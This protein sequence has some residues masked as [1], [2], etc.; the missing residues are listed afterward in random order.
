MSWLLLAALCALQPGWSTRE[1][2]SGRVYRIYAPAKAAAGLP[3]VLE[4]HGRGSNS[5]QQRVLSR[6]DDAADAGPF[7][8]VQPEAR[9]GQWNAG[10]CCGAADDAG[11][12]REVLSAL[13][14]ARPGRVHAVGFSN[15]GLFAQHLA[16]ALPGRLAS[17]ASVA[18]AVAFTG[19]K[20]QVPVLLIHGTD[21]AI[22]PFAGARSAEERWAVRNGCGPEKA[23]V[24]RKGATRCEQRLG[25]A[26]AV[27][28]C[29]VEGGGHTWPGGVA[30]PG[31]GQTDR[32]FDATAAIAAFFA[33]R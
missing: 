23:Q 8:L 7:L 27:E 11:F 12:V 29:T 9:D 13:D 21:D 4:F 33:R 22:L 25:C 14:C 24:L 18:G 26:A 20:T 1:T 10:P 3:L 15:G 32:G 16:C 6:L 2:P 5:A 31:L 30:L 28:L 19:C 17:I